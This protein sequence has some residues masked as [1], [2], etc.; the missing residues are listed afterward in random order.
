VAVVAAVLGWAGFRILSPRNVALHRSA[1]AL[2]VGMF[3][4]TAD[5]VVDGN[6]I[7]PFGYHSSDMD[8]P[9]LAIDLGGSYRIDRVEIFGR[10][11]CCFDQ[12]VPLGLSVSDD[13]I[14]YRKVADRNEAFSQ[15]EPWVVRS[16]G[17]GRHVRLELL[18]HGVLVLSEVEVFGR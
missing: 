16:V 6:M 18:R 10:G 2:G 5:G 15:R 11:D 3:G 13:G 17:T 4:T 8:G 7:S 1:S 12:S 9:W 14:T